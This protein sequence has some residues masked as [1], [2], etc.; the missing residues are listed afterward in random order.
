M[1][2]KEIKDKFVCTVHTSNIYHCVALLECKLRNGSNLV[3]RIQHLC[4]SAYQ[5]AQ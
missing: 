3:C 2:Y 5:G 1:E 4:T